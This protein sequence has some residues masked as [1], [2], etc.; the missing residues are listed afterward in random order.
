MLF[1]DIYL[2]IEKPAV[3]KLMIII[4]WVDILCLNRF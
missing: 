2:K 4:L 3:A 1:D